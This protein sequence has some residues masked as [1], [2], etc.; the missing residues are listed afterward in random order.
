MRKILL[1]EL[2]LEEQLVEL[3]VLHHHAT[4]SKIAG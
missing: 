3:E 4:I 2:A 1:K